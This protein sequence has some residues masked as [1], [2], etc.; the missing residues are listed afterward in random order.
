MF[1][2]LLHNG[3]F[4]VHTFTTAVMI[5]LCTVTSLLTAQTKGAY[6]G[7]HAPTYLWYSAGWPFQGWAWALLLGL[8]AFVGILGCV[9][10]TWRPNKYVI[11]LS[12]TVV[13]AGH[14]YVAQTIWDAFHYA[15]G[16]STYPLIALMG[17]WVFWR[18]N[19]K[20]GASDVFY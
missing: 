1:L 6:L 9:A 7:P 17:I 14:I 11:L 12:S 8:I 16:S 18:T 3:I 15:T 2:R 5:G 10:M 4:I 13:G 20:D 19:G